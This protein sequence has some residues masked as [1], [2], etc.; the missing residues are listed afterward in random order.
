MRGGTFLVRT[1]TGFQLLNLGDHSM[2]QAAGPGGQG[3]PGMPQ[4]QQIRLAIPTTMSSGL[5]NA[6]PRPPMSTITIP[7][8]AGPAPTAVRPAVTQPLTIN[9]TAATTGQPAPPSQM[10]PNTAKKKCKNFLSTLIRLA[11]DQPEH[12]AT[13]VRN[14]IQGLIVS[15]LIVMSHVA[16]LTFIYF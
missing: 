5:Q 16:T 6:I 8:T 7:G 11:S 2:H 12:V 4:T 15:S 10:S 14:L 13:N 9:T 1:P 3:T